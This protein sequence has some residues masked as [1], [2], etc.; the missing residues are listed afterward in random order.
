MATEETNIA[1]AIVQAAAE[2]AMVAVQA[3]AMAGAENSTRHK[4]K[5]NGGPT[6]GRP[7]MKHTAFN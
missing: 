3:M 2:A 1:Q 4:G 5:Q 7:M 6:I